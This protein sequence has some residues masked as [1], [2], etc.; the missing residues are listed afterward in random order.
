MMV[1]NYLVGMGNTP[2]LTWLSTQLRRAQAQLV[3][4]CNQVREQHALCVRQYVCV[5]VSLCVR[6]IVVATFDQKHIQ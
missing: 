5:G 1:M 2:K 6:K 3:A 4:A